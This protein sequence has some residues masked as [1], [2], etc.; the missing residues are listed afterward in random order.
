MTHLMDIYLQPSKVFADLKTRPTFVLPLLLTAL[1]GAAMILLY[2]MKVD[3]VW[4]ADHTAAAATAGSEMT[5]TEIAQAKKMMPGAR[6]MGYFGVAMALLGTAMAAALY[7]LYFMLAGKITG[8]GTSFKHGLSLS[9]WA[10]MPLLLGTVVALIGVFTMTPQTGL[11]ALMLTNVD[12][13]L[14]QLPADHPWSTFARS[15]SLLNLW[16]VFLIALGWRVWGR[17]SWT[18]AIVVAA[19]PSVVIYGAMA[20]WAMSR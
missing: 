2:S 14:V 8:A 16:A 4:F 10:G 12:P 18:Q 11:E 6:T 9:S 20:L 15:F 5:A 17:T 7:A 3:P 1:L 19:L 13:L